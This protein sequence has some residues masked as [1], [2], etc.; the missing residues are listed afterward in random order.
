MRADFPLHPTLWRTCRVMANRP[1]L[2][3]IAVLI[4]R[5]WSTVETVAEAVK[6]GSATASQ[7]LRALEARGLLQVRRQ[8]RY[9]K[10]R[11]ADKPSLGQSFA[12]ALA[13]IFKHKPDSIEIAFRTVTAFT[14]P[15]RIEIYRAICGPPRTVLQ[16]H[17][18]TK[19]PLWALNR[20]LKKIEARRFISVRAGRYSVVPRDDALGRLLSEQA[21]A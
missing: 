12:V 14:H 9:V 16:I 7:Y 11:L 18:A 21:A 8:G 4:A 2:Q 15:R 19:I 3:I 5:P 6:L 10:Y 17:A 1:R 13:R 20:H